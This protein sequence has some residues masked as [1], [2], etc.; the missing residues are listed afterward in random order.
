MPHRTTPP[1]TPRERMQRYHAKH[2]EKKEQFRLA[3]QAKRAAERQKR[4]AERLAIQ[5]PDPNGIDPAIM[6]RIASIT[7]RPKIVTGLAQDDIPIK[8][9]CAAQAA[10]E[11]SS[12]QGSKV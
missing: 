12:I 7:K 8:T 10:Q 5:L 4:D 2:P 6:E 11:N 3:M 9:G 1:L